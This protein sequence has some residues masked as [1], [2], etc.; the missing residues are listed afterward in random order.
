MNLVLTAVLDKTPRPDRETYTCSLRPMMD[1]NVCDHA[2]RNYAAP[3]AP[4]YKTGMMNLL[5]TAVAC[6]TPWPKMSG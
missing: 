5:F 3:L 4:D 1:W 2:S 6:N